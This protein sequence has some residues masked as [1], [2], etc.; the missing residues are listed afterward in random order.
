MSFKKLVAGVKTQQF[1]FRMACIEFMSVKLFCVI[2][3]NW[4]WCYFSIALADRHVSVETCSL[5]LINNYIN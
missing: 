4:E 5:L 3:L 1:S 2:V